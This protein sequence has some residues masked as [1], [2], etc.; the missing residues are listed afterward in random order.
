VSS[1]FEPRVP[2]TLQA[3][4]YFHAD[5]QEN[6]FVE[7]RGVY[8][9]PIGSGVLGPRGD[10][11]RV[12]DVWFSFDHHG[13]FGEGYHVFLEQVELDRDKLSPDARRYFQL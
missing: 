5:E 8:V 3:P 1:Q 2:R 9:L 11:Y 4:T 7:D 10:F 12:R 13:Y 6:W